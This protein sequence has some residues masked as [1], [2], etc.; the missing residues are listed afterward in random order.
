M[1]PLTLTSHVDADGVLRL[2]LPLGASE[3]NSDVRLTVES[4]PEESDT[5]EDHRKFVEEIAG[6]WQGD[7][8]RAPQPPYEERETL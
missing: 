6:L 2:A 8:E 5:I 4:I 3:A 7:F 1:I